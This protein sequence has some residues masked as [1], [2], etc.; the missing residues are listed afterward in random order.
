MSAATWKR[1]NNIRHRDIGYLIV[2]LTVAYGISGLAV[3]HTADW[4]PNYTVA[5]RTMKIDPVTKTS[6]EEII[7]DSRAKLGLDEEPQNAFRPDPETLQLFYPGET[8]SID[9]P[10]RFGN[11]L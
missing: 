4:D 9:L 10:T 7:A 6:R 11:I 8:Y 2:A 3:N 5:K 1:W